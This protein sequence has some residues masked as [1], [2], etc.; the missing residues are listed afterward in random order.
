[1]PMWA[2]IFILAA[3]LFLAL[4]MMLPGGILGI[5]AGVFLV[6]GIIMLYTI[7]TT[8]GLIATGVVLVLMPF[9]VLFALKWFPSSWVGR[10]LTLSTSQN[11]HT[12]VYD[13]ADA[14]VAAM[15]GAR[16]IAVTDLR[17]VGICRF[18]DRRLECLAESGMIRTGDN[19]Q[20]VSFGGGE[21]RVRKV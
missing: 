11:P 14:G 9:V 7:D 4:E 21:V 1:M 18:D 2:T 5:F 12:V 15:I 8:M 3:V 19:V 20:I 13:P 17:P 6:I 10:R 16:G